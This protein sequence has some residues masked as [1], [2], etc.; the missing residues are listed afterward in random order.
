MPMLNMPGVGVYSLT[1]LAEEQLAS[2]LGIP[3]KYYDKMKA[4]APSLLATNANHWFCK[5]TDKYMVRTLDNKV[6]GFLSS[7]FRPLDNFDLAEVVLP[8]LNKVGLNVVSCEVTDRRMYLKAVTDK[9]TAEITKG[10]VVQAG[11]VVS[12]SEV[13]CGSVK[14]EPMIYRLVCSNGM[15]ADDNSLR[16]Y[17]VG[18]GDNEGDLREY[19]KTETRQA[20]DKAFWMKVR[21]IVHSALGNGI[22][23]N[24]V[25][26]MK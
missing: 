25:E 26:K 4:E 1:D 3:K 19:F 12:N 20:D 14:I 5:G 22:F 8:E 11:I 24:S 7:R 18:R 10:D 23:K 6:R 2:R 9:I 15:I 17:H 16:K 13:G 21:D